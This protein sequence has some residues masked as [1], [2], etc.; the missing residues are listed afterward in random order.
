M[1]EVGEAVDSMAAGNTSDASYNVSK[2]NAI[3][4]EAKADRC[5]WAR[6][7][8]ARAP[9]GVPPRPALE[10]RSRESGIEH[11]PLPTPAANALSIQHGWSSKSSSPTSRNRCGSSGSS[12]RARVGLALRIAQRI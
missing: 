3:K 1:G 7:T 5:S 9:A 10:G 12:L 4:A 8:H 6:S 2:A 11:A